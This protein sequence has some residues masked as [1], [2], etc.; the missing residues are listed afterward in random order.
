MGV[1]I[2]YFYTKLQAIC[3]KILLSIKYFI[4]DRILWDRSETPTRFQMVMYEGVS[5]KF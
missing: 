1:N 2:M 3:C 5:N 4:A